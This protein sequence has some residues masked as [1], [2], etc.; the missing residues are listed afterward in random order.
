VLAPD[1]DWHLFA[2]DESAIPATF[3]MLEAL[4]PGVTALAF[5]EVDGPVDV[6]TPGPIVGDPQVHWVYRGDAEAGTSPVLN[7]VVAAAALPPGTGYAYLN[8]ELGTV[9]TLKATLTARGFAPEHISAKG[10]WSHGHANA[11]HGE[12]AR[13]R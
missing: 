6:Q 12:P 8:G 10:Y 5:I 7:D 11:A 13:D 1:V 9:N 2:A 3:A 4:A